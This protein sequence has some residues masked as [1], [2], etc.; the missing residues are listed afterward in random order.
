VVILD[1]DLLS[2]MEWTDSPSARRLVERLSAVPGEDI[3]TTVIT[4]EEQMRGWMTRLAKA[5][6]LLEQIE[7]YRRLRKRVE[8]YGSIKVLDFDEPAAVEF[9]RL[10]KEYR[11]LATT[12]LKIAA[13]TLSLKATLLSRNLRDYQQ[14][15]GLQVEDWTK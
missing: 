14:V 11:R 15:S 7:V 9:Q 12:D 5:K 3:A 1:T 2:L 8:L 4:V 6:K 10:K 13:I